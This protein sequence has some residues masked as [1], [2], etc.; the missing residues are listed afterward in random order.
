MA[1]EI[2]YPDTEGNIWNLCPQLKSSFPDLYRNDKSAGKAKSSSLLWGVFLITD[3]KSVY[4]TGIPMA[5]GDKI[6]EVS[7]HH[8]GDEKY[9]DSNKKVIDDLIERWNFLRGTSAMRKQYHAMLKK[10]DEKAV[11]LDS[12]KYDENTAE[13]IDKMMLNQEKLFKQMKEIETIIKEEDAANVSGG[14]EL[15]GIE[16]G[17]FKANKK[18]Q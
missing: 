14:G 9:Y 18:R 15:T 16:S 12:L 4:N 3:P 8:F 5:W 11:Y 17:R 6:R 1:F 2:E 10:M 13:D 7:K